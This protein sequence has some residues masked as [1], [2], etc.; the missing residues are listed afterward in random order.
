VVYLNV[1]KSVIEKIDKMNVSAQK[2]T[3]LKKVVQS[4][5][6]FIENFIKIVNEEMDVIKFKLSDSQKDFIR[7]KKRY[8]AVGKGR[9]QGFTSLMLALCLYTICVKPYSKILIGTYSQ[10]ARDELMDDL[11]KMYEFLNELNLPFVPQANKS[12]G[13]IGS[14]EHIKFDNGAIISAYTMSGMRDVGRGQ[15]YAIIFLTEV[16]FYEGDFENQRVAFENSLAKSEDAFIVMETTSKGYNHWYKLYSKAMN[17]EHIYK[18]FFYN[19]TTNRKIFE[20]EIKYAVKEWWIINHKKPLCID[21]L[22]IEELELHNEYGV[23]FD[24]LTWRR[25]KIAS[26]GEAKFKQE[27]PL[28]WWESF[29]SDADNNVFDTAKVQER[30]NHI[31]EP[32]KLKD[33]SKDL[34]EIA[35]KEYGRFFYMWE[36]VNKNKKYWLAAD[37][38][39][40]GGGDYSVI[41]VLDDDLIQVAEYRNNK[42]A[43]YM[44]A[45]L[46]VALAKYF[47]NALVIVENN[48]VGS[49]VL[50]RIYSE[51]KYRNLYK[52]KKFNVRGKKVTK[53]LGF[54]T[55]SETKPI[56]ISTFR[57]MFDNGKVLIN[58][59]VLLEEM[60]TYVITKNNKMTSTINAYD[61][62]VMAMALCLENY[63][64][65]V[66]LKVA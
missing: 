8:N 43:P 56:I 37:V 41:E 50:D 33:I 59:N 12:N 2:K 13:T 6:L 18:G 52:E 9:R 61:D 39:A 60:K 16:A 19:W 47:N 14:R 7:N 32:L 55:G 27:F 23:D 51:L 30:Q 36:N 54:Y 64:N 45:D 31:S 4:E 20:W 28:H 53:N 40:G 57:E 22:D 11:K 25:F 66:R 21:D 58:S 38:S 35:L 3:Q 29:Q 1:D 62:C 17:K 65:G 26:L 63:R 24:F 15:K 49:A 46:I 5:I 44:L 42:I 10:Q 48:N 34:P